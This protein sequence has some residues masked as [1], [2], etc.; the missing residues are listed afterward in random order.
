MTGI[1][2]FEAFVE[3]LIERAF[4]RIFSSPLHWSDLIR[5][6]ARAMENACRVTDGQLLF[7]D[8]YR[9]VLHPAD[10]EALKDGREELLSE[11]YQC[12]YHLAQEAGGRFATQP[13]LLVQL[14]PRVASGCVE[15]HAAWTEGA[16]GCAR[17]NRA[18][19]TRTDDTRPA[20]PVR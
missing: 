11:L 9:I 19:R 20:D 8:R 12:L 4:G 18:P 7:P 14:E 10:W 16:G 3:Q 1:E 17:T 2:H 6:M 15:V 5:D 13:A